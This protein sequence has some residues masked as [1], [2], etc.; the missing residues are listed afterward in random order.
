MSYFAMYIA[1]FFH[2]SLFKLNSLQYI[3]KC[4]SSSV[5]NFDVPVPPSTNIPVWFTTRAWPYLQPI[6][7]IFL[8]S[9]GVFVLIK[10]VTRSRSKS[11]QAWWLI[12]YS[13]WINIQSKSKI[14][15]PSLAKVL[16]INKFSST[17]HG[18]LQVILLYKNAWCCSQRSI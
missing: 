4:L 14:Y 15:Q 6:T 13:Y 8:I 1:I 9:A 11:M 5:V 16:S 2:L 12:C 10:V 3:T 17:L 7:C 18:K